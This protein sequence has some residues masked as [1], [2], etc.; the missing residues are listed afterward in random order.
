MMPDPKI[1]DSS[2]FCETKRSYHEDICYIRSCV[3]SIRLS[4]SCRQRQQHEPSISCSTCFHWQPY[5]RIMPLVICRQYDISAVRSLYTTSLP[6][7][8]RNIAVCVKSYIWKITND[9]VFLETPSLQGCYLLV[10]LM[11]H[12]NWFSVNIQYVNSKLLV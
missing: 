8:S 3:C 11:F 10:I 7:A 1:T 6:L 12:L 2:L 9:Y 5:M 4:C